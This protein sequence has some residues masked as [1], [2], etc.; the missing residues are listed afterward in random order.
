MGELNQKLQKKEWISNVGR[1]IS[2]RLLQYKRIY[3][4]A[5]LL[6]ALSVSLD[7]LLMFMEYRGNIGQ[8]NIFGIGE[9][10]FYT[11]FLLVVFFVLGS[12]NILSDSRISMYPGTI[13][14]RF[15]ARLCS[16]YL[17]FLGFTIIYGG[18]Y[19]VNSGL[20]H[21]LAK[22]EPNLN[23]ENTFSFNY[24]M[25]GMLQMFCGCLFL[26]SLFVLC[27][28]FFTKIRTITSIIL[29]AGVILLTNWLIAIEKLDLYE[30]WDLL[31]GK[32]RTLGR[33]LAFFLAVWGICTLLSFLIVLRIGAF[34]T[35]SYYLF[36]IVLTGL[37]LGGSSCIRMME[38]ISAYEG[39]AYREKEY[40]FLK[41]ALRKD[42][43]FRFSD[44]KQG[45]QI[46]HQVLDGIMPKEEGGVLPLFQEK[47]LTEKEAKEEGYLEQDFFLE[48]NQML[49]RVAVSDL[50]YRKQY[51][52]EN[53]I[54]GL[55][56]YQEGSD[57]FWK[58]KRCGN[59]I[60]AAFGKDYEKCHDTEYDISRYLKRWWV[61]EMQGVLV[62]DD[63]LMEVWA[64]EESDSLNQ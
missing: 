15:C 63:A 31:I 44:A 30:V 41:K 42:F 10:P 46:I 19:I 57:I 58:R 12:Y 9:L 18:F 4:G 16:D 29:T 5:A 64:Q 45:S 60:S 35:S 43:T 40:Y 26:Y 36:W 59:V 27:Y 51:I 13:S 6:L 61:D 22:G 3:L 8:K 21:I 39:T 56:V 2:I 52:Y 53:I 25:A 32:G 28:T 62:V 55:D 14:S 24:L 17:I 1:L 34:K 33:Y 23:V 37:A 48:K 7:L 20:L 49:F 47:V 11:A 54:K 50:A 38:S